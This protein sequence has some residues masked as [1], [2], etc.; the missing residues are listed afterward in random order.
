MSVKKTGIVFGM[1]YDPWINLAA[2]EFLLQRLGPDE[3]ML[4]LWQNQ[5]TVVV[6]RHQN[7]WRECHV[8]RLE[9]D[10][11]KLARRLSGGGAVYHD[12]GNLN[13]T[14]LLPKQAYDL[15]RQLKVILSAARAVGVEAEF[16]GRND[17]LALGRKFSGNA[18]YHGQR[19]SYHHGTILIDVDMGVLANYLNVPA[20]KMTAKGV[21]SVK[22]RVINLREL[23]PTLSIEDMKSALARAFVAEYGGSGEEYSL[24]EFTDTAEFTALY[25]K[26]SSWD[27]RLGK[28]PDFDITYETR[29]PWGGIEI[30]LTVSGGVVE[31][32]RIYSDAME[33]E[34]IEPMA[35]SLL[36]TSFARACLAERLLL[37][38]KGH[39]SP[40]IAEVAA[41]LQGES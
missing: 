37:L 28:S 32:A 2:E 40:L 1:G 41:W 18:F 4:Y 25:A 15:H 7:A 22:S 33:A 23:V 39:S 16:S 38:S 21:A 29:F 11:G 27:F 20:E 31:G 17:I 14:F 24:G 34:L 10:G 26:Y 9:G 35:D 30:G 12:L 6:G 3:A 19:S 5:H 8:A 36:G 13:F